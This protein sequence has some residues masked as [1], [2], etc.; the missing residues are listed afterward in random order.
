MAMTSSS[1][2]DTS[3]YATFFRAHFAS[4][5]RSVISIAGTAAEDVAQEAF[6]AAL[7]RW[8]HVVDLEAPDAWVR[9]V[10]KR[11][12][13]RRRHRESNR[14]EL[15]AEALPRA[16]P[17][18]DESLSID[19]QRAIYGLPTRQRAVIQLH[20]LA[21]RS[22]ADVAEI[23]GC[24]EAAAKIWLYRARGRLAETLM[25]HGGRWVSERH[26]GE[27]DIAARMRARSSSSPRWYA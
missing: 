18:Y 5:V 12:A 8:E 27:D 10:A 19:L 17:V 14:R 26:W 25:G 16:T 6:I 2:S 15:E 24:S 9:L 21:D 20:Y 1:A 23:L 3:E 4:T 7:A 22:V 11:I 13:W